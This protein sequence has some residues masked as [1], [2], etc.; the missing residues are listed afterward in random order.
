MC[1]ILYGPLYAIF[2]AKLYK[3]SIPGTNIKLKIASLDC[4][5]STPTYYHYGNRVNDLAINIMIVLR[6][7]PKIRKRLPFFTERTPWSEMDYYVS[8]KELVFRPATLAK[9]QKFIL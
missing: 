4:K 6:G 8:E 9:G 5:I 2:C 7:Y 3:I 1:Y